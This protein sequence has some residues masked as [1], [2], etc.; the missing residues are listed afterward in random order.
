MMAHLYLGVPP[1]P[2]FYFIDVVQSSRPS[3][4]ESSN[5]AAFWNHDDTEFSYTPTITTFRGWCCA[6]VVAR[7]CCGC[8][9]VV[10]VLLWHGCGVGVWIGECNKIRLSGSEFRA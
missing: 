10:V 5:D 3:G 7:L 8:A 2:Y 6:A 1:L 4:S 9:A